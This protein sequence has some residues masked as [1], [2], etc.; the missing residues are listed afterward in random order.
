MSADQATVFVVD[1]DDAMRSSLRWLIES[2]G[3]MVK[4]FDSALDYLEAFDPDEAGCLVLDVRMPGMS[5]MELLENLSAYPLRPP[6]IIITGHGDV[7]MAV[8]AIKY[9][10]LDFIQKPFNDQELLDRIQQALDTDARNRQE[11]AGLDNLKS[12]YDALTP[13]ERQIMDMVAAGKSNKVVASELEISSRTVEVHRARIMKKLKVKT[14]ADLV[15]ANL[16]LGSK[17]AG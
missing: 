4:T 11:M 2:V 8:R 14:L 7:P 17:A 6:V 16:Q 3:L 15:Q 10:A 13:R 12:R 1:D 5:G 9:G